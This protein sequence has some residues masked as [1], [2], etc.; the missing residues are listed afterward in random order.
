MLEVW[1]EKTRCSIA[2]VAFVQIAVHSRI[3]LQRFAFEVTPVVLY[4][5]PYSRL[6]PVKTIIATEN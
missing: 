4:G 6:T 5:G 2:G 3:W 1:V